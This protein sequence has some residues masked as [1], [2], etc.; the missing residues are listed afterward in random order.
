MIALLYALVI[1]DLFC[2]Y[3]CVVLLSQNGKMNPSNRHLHYFPSNSK[4]SRMTFEKC[5][6][7][8]TWLFKDLMTFQN[9]QSFNAGQFF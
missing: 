9:S 7:L 5:I 1:G 8:N 2:I 6:L 3:I 4:V